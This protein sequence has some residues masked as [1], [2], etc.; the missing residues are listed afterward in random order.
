MATKF[1]NN[2]NYFTHHRMTVN[3]VAATHMLVD[4]KSGGWKIGFEYVDSEGGW[5]GTCAGENIQA[6]EEKFA[7]SAMIGVADSG[8]ARAARGNLLMTKLQ[9]SVH[10]K[11]TNSWYGPAGSSVCGV[12][13]FK[14]FGSHHFT[15]IA[16]GGSCSNETS[17]D[18]V[19]V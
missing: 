12:A 8:E 11:Y 7:L 17:F 5:T 9:R 14:D 1:S 13:L 10:T 15:L 2:D 19:A 3:L 6:F 18:V 4:S 16:R